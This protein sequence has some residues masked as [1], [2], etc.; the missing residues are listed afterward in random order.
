MSGT[1]LG[2]VPDRAVRL[3]GAQDQLNE[4]VTA[5]NVVVDDAFT[6]TGP[7]NESATA[8]GRDLKGNLIF[9]GGNTLGD[10]VSKPMTLFNNA[11][12][13][14]SK[15][16]LEVSRVGAGAGVLLPAGRIAEVGDGFVHLAIFN[17]TGAGVTIDLKLRVTVD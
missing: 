4:G 10:G 7:A 14:T 12:R 8:N 3:T 9:S 13:A 1:P 11:I 17:D 15:I 6:V 5:P 16:G 2:L